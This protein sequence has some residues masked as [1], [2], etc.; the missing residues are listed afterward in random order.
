MVS[1]AS[2]SGTVVPSFRL[3]FTPTAGF[4]TW[5]VPVVNRLLNRVQAKVK[6]PESTFN[7]VFIRASADP[8]L[9]T[10]CSFDK[11]LL[12]FGVQSKLSL[13]SLGR[14]WTVELE[15]LEVQDDNLTAFIKVA[16]LSGSATTSK[17][18]HPKKGG[19]D[20][21]PRSRSRS[22]P[23]RSQPSEPTASK[24]RAA[25]TKR[26]VFGT[27]EGKK[28]ASSPVDGRGR[29]GIESATTKVLRTTSPHSGHT[30]RRPHTTPPS[31]E[32]LFVQQVCQPPLV[33]RPS[34]PQ[35]QMSHGMRPWHCLQELRSSLPM[36]WTPSRSTRHKP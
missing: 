1:P 23:H 11:V 5:Q 35:V 22:P 15:D 28:R 25:Q 9:L 29:P 18:D 31:V 16:E 21:R 19:D 20:K 36:T 26:P 33:R 27:G 13:L 34:L 7:W 8:I 30:S 12:Q 2:G 10:G 17:V 3:S 24:S 32:R 4:P 6:S 14:V